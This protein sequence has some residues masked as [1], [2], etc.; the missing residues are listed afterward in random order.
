MNQI[1]TPEIHHNPLTQWFRQPKI[2]VRL[3]SNGDF[4][5]KGALDKSVNG[6]YAVFA[7]TAKDELMIKT[8]DAMI[9]G[10]STVEVIKSCIPAII[11]PWAM[12]SIDL[13][14]ALLA[15]R[16]ATYGESMDV[17]AECPHCKEENDF[18]VNLV[19]WLEK[20][21]GF[22]FNTTLK[23]DPLVLHIRPYTYR[24]I[25]QASLKTFEQ[26]RIISIVNDDNVSDEIKIEKFSESF[27]K[28][29]ELT[30]DTMARCVWKITTPNGETEHYPDIVEFI[31]NSPKE[32]FQQISDHMNEI[33]AQIE[34]GAQNV[35][36]AHCNTEFTMP[37]ELDHS[38]FFGKRS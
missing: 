8:P 4:Y 38:S 18:E 29:T 12:P 23:I 20:L 37:V 27:I 24:E 22:E 28:L 6:E 25:T 7:M 11:D 13:D 10:Q 3:P 34:M 14:A 30:V 31:H 26:Q 1:K 36:C 35:T 21:N 17:G 9:S 5:V 33:K 19:G 32:I 15:I 2:Y 16:I